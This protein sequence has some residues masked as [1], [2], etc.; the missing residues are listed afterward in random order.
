MAITPLFSHI[1]D[2]DVFVSIIK[3]VG[4]DTQ[5]RTL[6]SVNPA[7]FMRVSAYICALRVIIYDLHT[8]KKG[9]KKLF[10]IRYEI[11]FLGI[12]LFSLFPFEVA[13]RE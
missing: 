1:D 8:L 12:E 2:D 7:L 13:A 5:T 10:L 11:A 6:L 9:A 3:L 4:I